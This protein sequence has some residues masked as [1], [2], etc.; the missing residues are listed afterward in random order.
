MKSK[1]YLHNL[2][3]TLIELLVVISII[4]VLAT[5]VIA[6]L[7]ETRARAR[8]LRRKQGLTQLK[9]ALQ[10]YYNDYKM[11]PNDNNGRY[12]ALCGSGTTSCQMGDPL[13]VGETTYMSS[14]PEYQYDQTQTGDSYILKVI[15]ENTSD[16]DLLP[17]QTRCPEGSYAATEYAVCPN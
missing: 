3:F 2:G 7:N 12:I 14:L 15:L 8:D 6:N 16:P 9:T 11:Y 17:S 13:T 1:T 5:L 4:G 10:L